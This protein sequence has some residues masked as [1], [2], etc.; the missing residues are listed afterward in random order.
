MVGIVINSTAIS[1]NDLSLVL[2][3]LI[4]PWTDLDVLQTPRHATIASIFCIVVCHY[5]F[6]NDTLLITF[7]T[8]RRNSELESP[9]A[10]QFVAPY[11]EYNA[12][13]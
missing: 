3:L 10:R 9:N 6:L 8:R 12:Q 11:Y 5:S 2:Q 13:S 7:G 4:K 1:T